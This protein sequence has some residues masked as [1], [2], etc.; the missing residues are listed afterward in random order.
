MSRSVWSLFLIQSLL[1]YAL[2]L[3]LLLT[4][5]SLDPAVHTPAIEAHAI[6]YSGSLMLAFGVGSSLALRANRWREVELLVLIQIILCLATAVGLALTIFLRGASTT[7]WVAVLVYAGLGGIWVM[8]FLKNTKEVRGP[9]I[10]IK[11]F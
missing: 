1:S 11:E 4:I 8:L 5:V 6:A 3:G 2:G 7:L 10:N 9:G